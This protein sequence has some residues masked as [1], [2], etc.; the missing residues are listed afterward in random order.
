MIGHATDLSH[1]SKAT[2][3]RGGKLPCTSFI[4]VPSEVELI[5][6]WGLPDD[7]YSKIWGTYNHG[8]LQGRTSASS[9]MTAEEVVVVLMYIC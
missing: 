2:A 8:R 1:E 3:L 9:K 4:V 7:I 6:T 5:I